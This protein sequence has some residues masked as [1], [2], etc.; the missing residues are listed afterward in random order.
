M[1]LAFSLPL[2]WPPL[3]GIRQRIVRITADAAYPTGGWAI[4]PANCQLTSITQI[5]PESVGGYVFEWDE[6]AQ[7]LKAYWG[8][9]NNA[10]D[11]PL[12][13]I[14]VND[15]G[16]NAKVVTCMVVGR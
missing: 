5:F 7:K 3:K 1:A 13:E 11:G 2:R 6:A 8:D 10:S 16:V 14:P 12:I 9:N 15:A 4:T